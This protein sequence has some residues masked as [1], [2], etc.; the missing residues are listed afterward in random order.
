MEDHKRRSEIAAKA[1]R[2]LGYDDFVTFFAVVEN[3]KVLELRLMEGHRN[4]VSRI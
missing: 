3:V 2:E 1:L 4:P